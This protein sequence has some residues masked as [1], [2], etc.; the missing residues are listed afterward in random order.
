MYYSQLTVNVKQNYAI[1]ESLSL[2]IKDA[3]TLLA[4]YGAKLSDTNTLNITFTKNNS[5]KKTN[6]TVP[7]PEHGYTWD[8]A[9]NL[10]KKEATIQI[11]SGSEQGLVFGLYGFLQEKLGILFYHPK[12]TKIPSPTK[13]EL[14]TGFSLK[15]KPKFQ[16][17]GFHLHTQHPLE[18]TEY[19]LEDEWGVKGQDEVKQYVDWL[20]RNGQ[21]Y[22]QFFLLESVKTKKWIKYFKP[23]EEYAHKRGLLVGLNTTL[24]MIQQK[25]YKLYNNWPA[26]WLTRKKQISNRIK[27]LNEIKWDYWSIDFKTHEFTADKSKRID[28]LKLHTYNELKKFDT[29][30][31]EHYHVVYHPDHLE[32]ELDSLQQDFINHT[33]GLIHTVMFYTI[34]DEKAPVYE[35]DNLQHMKSKLINSKESGRETWYFPESAYWVTFDNSIPMMLNPYL[36]ARLEDIETVS[37]LNVDAHLTFSSGWE[38]GYWLYDWSIARWSWDYQ[39]D[40]SPFQFMAEIVD[41]NK[42][43]DK[44][45]KLSNLQDEYIKDSNLIEW[46]TA[47]TATDEAPKWIF[48]K[49]FHPRPPFSYKYLRNEA[50]MDELNFVRGKIKLLNQF[51]VKSEKILFTIQKDYPSVVNEFIDGFKITVLRAKHRQNI[52]DYLVKKRLQ[53]DRLDKSKLELDGI[54]ANAKLI[55]AEAQ[56]IV[57]NRVPNY[58]YPNVIIGSKYKGKTAYGFGYLYTVSNLHFWEREELQAEKNKYKVRYRNIYNLMRIAGFV[59]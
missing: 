57:N 27:R 53:Q 17:K 6:S 25:A 24:H 18:L 41:D 47:Q 20:V 43:M 9:Y 3:N 21:N 50:N 34:T 22:F 46:L 54:M 39:R 26:S 55:R 16:L 58:R 10:S 36:T 32:E 7:Y 4:S 37:N 5:V 49:E 48:N 44:F 42:L 38:W 35:N 2:S 29:K 56:I 12:E 19:L 45:T 11:E 30:V 23:I 15:V 40:E 14:T 8:Y 28:R 59:N 31:G 13:W 51:I 52:L 1:G 33:A